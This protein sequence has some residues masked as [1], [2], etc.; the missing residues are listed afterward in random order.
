MLDAIL[1]YTT[2]GYIPTVFTDENQKRYKTV[3]VTDNIEIGGLPRRMEGN[4]LSRHSKVLMADEPANSFRLL[5][6]CPTTIYAVPIPVN[7]SAPM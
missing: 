4:H 7:E 5:P 3:E 2:T 1:E 6:S